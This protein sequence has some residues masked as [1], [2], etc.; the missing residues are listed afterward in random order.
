MVNNLLNFNNIKLDLA[1]F[2][3][4]LKSC[5]HGKTYMID[6]GYEFDGRAISDISKD[7]LEQ[8]A[9][10]IKDRDLKNIVISGIFSPVNP[11]QEKTSA[12]IIR[13]IYP[14]CSITLSH[15]IGHI[16]ILERENAAI[17]NESLKPLCYHTICAFRK[18][19]S[20]LNLQCPFYLTQ[21]D[22]TLI[23]Y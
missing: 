22:G 18:T 5:I 23:R 13:Q 19:L 14:R 1:D 9:R 20:D 8:C 17:L 7:E 15:T 11:Q 16:G 21:N 12:E 10:D 2:P 3:A 4:D 6:G